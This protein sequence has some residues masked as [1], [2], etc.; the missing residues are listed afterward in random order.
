MPGMRFLQRVQKC[1][2]VGG[3]RNVPGIPAQQ[4]QLECRAAG[5]AL[6]HVLHRRR[7]RAR[8]KP[9][10]KVCECVHTPA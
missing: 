1:L 6:L 10:D 8:V 5:D 2:H 3:T 9:G 4:K 7:R